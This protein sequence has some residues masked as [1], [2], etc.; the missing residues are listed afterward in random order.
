[1]QA[2]NRVQLVGTLPR[3]PEMRYTPNGT[4]V[5]SF[6]VLTYRG[7]KD[8][9]GQQ[10]ESPEYNN[11]V[12][13]SKLAEICNQLLVSGSNVFIEGRLQTRSWDDQDNI[14]HYKTEIIADDMVLLGG[15]AGTESVTDDTPPCASECLNRVQVIGNL[16][17]D[18]ELRYLNSGTPVTTFVVATNRS[19]TN[20]DGDRK[21]STEFHN[22]VCWNALAESI[23]KKIV[24][25]QKVFL[26]GRLQNRSWE[27]QDGIKRYKTEIVAELIIDSTVR[28]EMRAASENEDSSDRAVDTSTPEV[29]EESSN[30]DSNQTEVKSDSSQSETQTVSE[31]TP[32][33]SADADEAKEEPVVSVSAS[34]DSGIDDEIPF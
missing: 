1:M 22:V 19:W 13:W 5:T 17:R 9:S 2:L 10:Q 26:E 32:A 30:Q 16:A 12:V 23:S 15:R 27:G 3:D 7:W 24:K 4:A 11:V 34:D 33:E 8:D 28:E 29:E 25:G 21:E 18:P 14:K 6:T 20:S 31:E